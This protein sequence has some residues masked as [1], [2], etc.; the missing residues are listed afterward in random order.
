MNGALLTL[1]LIGVVSSGLLV[2]D[3][4][5]AVDMFIKI[6]DIDGEALHPESREPGWMELNSLHWEVG[7][8][9]HPTGSSNREASSPSI[10]EVTVTKQ[11]DSTSTEL[12]K[13]ACCGNSKTVKIDLIS[14]ATD[15]QQKFYT[16]TLKNAKITSHSSNADSEQASE[17][18]SLNFEEIKW[19]YRDTNPDTTDGSFEISKTPGH[20]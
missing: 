14:T 18:F 5:A 1:A 9:I 13:E 15:G 11:M 6:P 2:S 7:R 20:R 8:S 12:M 17:S 3:A 16:V 4:F 10:S 19:E